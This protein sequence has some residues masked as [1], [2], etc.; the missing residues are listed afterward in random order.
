LIEFSDF[1]T[2][3]LVLNFVFEVDQN[4]ELLAVPKKTKIS[5]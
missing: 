5:I 3:A 2:A 1:A 4:K